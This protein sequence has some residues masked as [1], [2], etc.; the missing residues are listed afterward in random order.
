MTMT[1]SMPIIA[2]KAK[3]YV[4]GVTHSHTQSECVTSLFMGW[5][6]VQ[7]SHRSSS[8]EDASAAPPPGP[9]RALLI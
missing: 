6:H 2:T 5:W 3:D 4:R 9:T 7:Y 1:L 8:S